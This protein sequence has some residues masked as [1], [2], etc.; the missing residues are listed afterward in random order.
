MKQ[1]TIDIE[2]R[3]FGR[4]KT[5]IHAWVLTKGGTRVPC[6]IQNLSPR[7]A[8][9]EFPNGAPATEK[10]RLVFG[11][12]QRER[13]CVV[14]HRQPNTLGVSFDILTKFEE[15]DVWAKVD[16]ERTWTRLFERHSYIGRKI[17]GSA[18]KG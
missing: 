10:F 2:R 14:R 9:L 4:R 11:A 8:L 7:G 18:S 13:R 16:R 6:I 12:D 1:K 15:R 17:H 3:Q 5:V